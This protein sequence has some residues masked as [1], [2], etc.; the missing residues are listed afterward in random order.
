MIKAYYCRI[1]FSV[2]SL[3]TFISHIFRYIEYWRKYK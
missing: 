1:V 3:R 2:I